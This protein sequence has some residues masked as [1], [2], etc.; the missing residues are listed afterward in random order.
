MTKARCWSCGLPYSKFPLDLLVPRAQWLLI[1]R[2]RES[3]LLCAACIVRRMR[4][5]IKGVT[6]IHAVG[7]VAP[8]DKESA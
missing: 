6:V 4:R 5:C 7:E 2:G 8:R 1:N 3:G